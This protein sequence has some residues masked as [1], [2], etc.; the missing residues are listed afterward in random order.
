MR[1]TGGAALPGEKVGAGGMT[2]LPF[3]PPGVCAPAD[4]CG[5]QSRIS[6]NNG[7]MPLWRN[8]SDMGITGGKKGKRIQK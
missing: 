2:T 7:A 5:R 8:L 4:A 3:Q 6:P 1:I